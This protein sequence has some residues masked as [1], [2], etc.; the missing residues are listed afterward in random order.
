MKITICGSIAFYDEMLEIKRK[1]EEL[2]HEV[3][4]PPKEII[5]KDGNKIPAKEY[6]KIRKKGSAEEKWIWDRK[7]DA[8]KLHFNKVEWSN[9]ILVLNYNKNEIE[10]YIG[11][12]SLMEIGLAFYLNKKIYFV[13]KI[14]Q[15][16]YTEEILGM[17]PEIIN[18]NL[19]LIR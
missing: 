19:N 10:G 14:P 17:K 5:D 1:L 8:M 18:G 15:M 7:R 4:L 3:E 12:N 2:G 9:A 13:N 11:A 6:Y 16:P